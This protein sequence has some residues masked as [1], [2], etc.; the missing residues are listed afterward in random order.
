MYRRIIIRIQNKVMIK[1]CHY[2]NHTIINGINVTLLQPMKTLGLLNKG[3]HPKNYR[4]KRLY[5]DKLFKAA[6]TIDGFL[7]HYKNI[8]RRFE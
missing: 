1:L 7:I 8:L 2:T 3:L 5:S 6:Q 4:I